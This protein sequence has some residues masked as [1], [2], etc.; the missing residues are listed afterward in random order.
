M[1]KGLTEHAQKAL[2]RLQESNSANWATRGAILSSADRNNPNWRLHKAIESFLGAQQITHAGDTLNSYCQ[3]ILADILKQDGSVFNLL[4]DLGIAKTVEKAISK[5]K[6]HQAPD[7][8]IRAA[9][10]DRIMTFWSP[11]SDIVAK[12]RNKFVHQNGHDPNREV[13]N[14][15]KSKHG[16]WCPLPPTDLVSGHIP[17]SYIADEWLKADAELG[18]WACRHVLHHI[19][20]MDQNLSHRFGLP[21]ERWR[22]RPIGLSFRGT[23]TP[24]FL[25]PGMPLPTTPPQI[26]RIFN[27]KITHPPD[28][29]YSMIPVEEEKH[30][31]Q[32][33]LRLK[34]DIWT[35]INAYCEE[36]D[37]DIG[38]SSCGLAGSILTHT[39]ST[40]D[41]SLDYELSPIGGASDAVRNHLGIRL[42]QKDFVPFVTVWASKNM[43]RDFVTDTL[44]YELKEYLKDCID[45]TI[46]G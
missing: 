12:L 11:E 1:S 38:A 30:C 39:I 2:E 9:M 6:L 27:T 18:H 10:R 3:S 33:W 29:D 28:P 16:K 43:M 31:A 36:A 5:L 17:V 14:E 40:H 32:T 4:H 35:F 42:R 45:K 24:A 13:E 46:T 22:P 21:R 23:S 26:E 44:S 15:I 25:I 37:V 41:F 20:L 19:H 7:G 8:V 34:H